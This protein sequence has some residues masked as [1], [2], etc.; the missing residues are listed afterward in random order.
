[1]ANDDDVLMIITNFFVKSRD[2]NGVPAS[3]L[4][5]VVGRSWS[6]VQEILQ[7]LVTDRKVNLAF[8]SNAVNPHVKRLL[9][10]PPDVQ[11]SKL[12]SEDPDGICA[13]PGQSILHDAVDASPYREV[14][15]TYRLALAEA[16]LTA[17][18]FELKVLEGYFRDPRYRCSF[19]DTDG[20]ISVSDQHYQSAQM[21]EKDKVVL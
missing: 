14:P 8:S 17:V 11:L 13:Y 6:E 2:F 18:F 1:M 16:Q 19:Q 10:L 21:A 15:Y 4:A 9:D 7:R 12:A 20:R 3:H 5:K